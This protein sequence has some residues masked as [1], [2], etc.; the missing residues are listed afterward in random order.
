MANEDK[1]LELIERKLSSQRCEVGRVGQTLN[2][3]AGRGITAAKANVDPGRLFDELYATDGDHQ[4]LIA[5]FVSG[6]RH[7]L[8][9]PKRSDAAEWDF[10]T[11]AG[12]MMLN[13]EVHTFDLGVRAAAGEPAWTGGYFEDLIVGYFIELDVGIRV[14]TQSQFE[15][16]SAT[17]E[18]VYAAARSMLFHKSRNLKPREIDD[19]AGVEELNAGDSYDAMR[20][21]VVSDLFFSEF[22]DDFRF[23]TPTQDALLFVRGDSDDQLSSL[24]EATDAYTDEADYPLSRSIYGFE[25]GKP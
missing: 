17:S 11:A 5:G 19:F 23:S 1:W 14:L 22:G 4:R 9:E 25:T 3:K 2:V 21:I 12:R 20:S 18:R 7:V 8:L 13:V 10:L 6:V 24:R 15:S 16:W